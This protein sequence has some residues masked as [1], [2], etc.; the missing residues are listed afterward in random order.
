MIKKI[1]AVSVF[2]LV[3]SLTTC[4]SLTAEARQLNTKVTKIIKVNKETDLLS[5][6]YLKGL[7]LKR[8]ANH[9]N[10]MV[11]KVSKYNQK[12]WYV[13]SGNT[14]GG[15]DCSGL[16]MWAYDQIGIKLEHRASKQKYS[17]KLVRTPKP[18]DIVAFGW[19]GY[20]D[21]GHVGIYLGNGMMIHAG[22]KGERTSIVNVQKWG[23]YY[24]NITY[25]RLLD[26][27]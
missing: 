11:N 16:V 22:R 24:T 19:K 13:F 18:G 6:N 27:F 17:G 20:K 3:L 26:T 7:E 4:H 21:A 9:I 2:T 25:T 12:T 8:N 10:A 14:P 1:A 15:W 23:K 5:D